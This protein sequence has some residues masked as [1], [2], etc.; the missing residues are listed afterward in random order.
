[1]NI[2]INGGQLKSMIDKPRSGMNGKNIINVTRLG[3]LTEASYWNIRVLH[4]D[5]R[6]IMKSLVSR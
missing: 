4:K 6:N 2:S 3:N 1:M 5:Y